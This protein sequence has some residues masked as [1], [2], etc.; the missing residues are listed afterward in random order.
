MP[1]SS[2]EP[3]AAEGRRF[4][5]RIAAIIH[6]HQSAALMAALDDAHYVN[7]RPVS[8]D[9]SAECTIMPITA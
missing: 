2:S 5:F 6:N 1:I 3:S 7:L 9:F 4:L 8:A